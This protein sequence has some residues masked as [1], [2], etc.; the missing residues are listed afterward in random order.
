MKWKIS[1]KGHPK[2]TATHPTTFMLT[3]ECEIFG[4]GDCIVGVATERSAAELPA[5]LK[6]MLLL[7]KKIIITLSTEDV[8]EKIVAEGR[9]TLTFSDPLDIVIRKSDFVCGRTVAVKA[10]KAARDFSRD[11]VK[12]LQNSSARIEMEIE[13]K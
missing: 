12:L 1:A 13:V 5:E 9:R 3:K 11:F 2:I 10:N 6:R 4:R 8:S 7:S